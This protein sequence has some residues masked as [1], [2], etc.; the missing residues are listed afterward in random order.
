VDGALA[1]ALGA[2]ATALDDALGALSPFA[3]AFAHPAHA[4]TTPRTTREA[5]PE[6]DQRA[7]LIASAVSYR[8]PPTPRRADAPRA[9]SPSRAREA[10]FAA[11]LR[12]AARIADY[13][14]DAR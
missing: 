2:L 10:R 5:M 8:A 9:D 4:T 11:P 14:P 12:S 7:V 13:L 1:N 6:I 3:R